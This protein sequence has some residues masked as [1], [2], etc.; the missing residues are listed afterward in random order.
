MIAATLVHVDAVVL[1]LAG[2][3]ATGVETWNLAEYV[4]AFPPLGG[5]VGS[6]AS[7]RLY[8]S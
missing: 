7:V 1:Q 6:S 5:A 2:V 3:G 8:S 4:T